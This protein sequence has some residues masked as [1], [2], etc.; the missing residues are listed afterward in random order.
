M[1]VLI[2]AVVEDLL[3][4]KQEVPV[5]SSYQMRTITTKKIAITYS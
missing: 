3:Y 5:T 2:T 4:A 1:T